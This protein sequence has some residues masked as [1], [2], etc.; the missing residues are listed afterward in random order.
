MSDQNWADEPVVPPKKKGLPGWLLFC[1]AGCLLLA[2]LAAVGAFFVVKEAQK[3]M[4]PMAQW[5]RLDQ[6]IELDARPP[7]LSM[8]FGWGVGIDLWMIYDQRGYIA[9]VYDFGEAEADART[10][11]FSEDFAGG[12]VPG[13]NKMEDPELGEV[14]VQGR[15]L[16][17]MRI[18]NKGGFQPAG[19]QGVSGDS[20]ACFVD[21]TPEGDPGFKMLFLLR[22]PNRGEQAMEPVPDEAVQTFLEPF[23][24]GPDREVYVAPPGTGADRGFQ[25]MLD[26]ASRLESDRM[27][28]EVPEPPADAGD[29][30]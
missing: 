12:G 1:G 28:D 27:V 3:A 15:T 14:V 24:I 4:D 16:P 26:A 20:A 6:S 5:E 30:Q 17:V 23:V 10:E 29:G 25:G 8:M 18:V 21:L 22:D 19:G 11:I 7:E 2:V 9:A 13:M